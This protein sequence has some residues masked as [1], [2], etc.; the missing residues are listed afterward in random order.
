MLH[1]K[2]GGTP[3]VQA[4]VKLLRLGILALP[5]FKD[6]QIRQAHQ[7][8]WVMFPENFSKSAVGLVLDLL[9]RLPVSLRQIQAREIAMKSYRI[10]VLLG[11]QQFSIQ[12][13]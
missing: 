4:P 2:Y 5:M 7:G 1:S 9:R 13:Y 3:A 6:G 8:R 11:F 10:W 12:Q